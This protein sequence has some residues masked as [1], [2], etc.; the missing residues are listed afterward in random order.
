M[1]GSEG[2]HTREQFCFARPWKPDGK[3]VRGWCERQ[4][5]LVLRSPSACTIF[6]VMR[7]KSSWRNWTYCPSLALDR[8]QSAAK[9][10]Q[11]QYEPNMIVSTL[12]PKIQDEE[13]SELGLCGGVV[14]L[15]SCHIDSEKTSSF[16][17][18]AS[19]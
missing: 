3:A 2:Q 12:S 1:P 17:S 19:C 9:D 13:I 6:V 5:A 10:P 16:I 7:S 15:S 8:T 4:A 14:L 18:H 11:N